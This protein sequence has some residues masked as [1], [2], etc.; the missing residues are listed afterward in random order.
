MSND[1]ENIKIDNNKKSSFQNVREKLNID[2]IKNK[3][4]HDTVAIT[5]ITLVSGLA[6]GIVHA[7]TAGPIAYQEQKAKEEAYK[8]VFSEAESFEPVFEE[9]NPDVEKH[10]DETGYTRQDIDEKVAAVDGAGNLVGYAYTVTTHEGYGGD[11]KFIVGVDKEGNVTPISILSISE[12]AGLGMRANTDEFKQQF[13]GKPATVVLVYTKDGAD[14]VFEI[15]ALS[16]AT[17]TTKAMTNGVNAG[18]ETYRYQDGNEEAGVA[19]TEEAAEDV[20]RAAPAAEEAPVVEEVQQPAETPAEAPVAEEVQQPAEAPVAEEVQQPAEAPV[21][22]EVQQPAEAPVVEEV[23]QPAE[24]PVVE[25]VQPAE[26][27]AEA[28]AEVP[29]AGEV[30][31]PAETP[32]EAPVAEETQQP[33][34]TPEEAPVAE[35]VQQPAET[36]A[37]EEVRQ[38][39][40]TPAAEEVQQPAETP[41]AEEV[42]QPAEEEPAETVKDPGLFNVFPVTKAAEAAAK[43]NKDMTKKEGERYESYGSKQ[44]ERA[45]A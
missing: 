2:R 27:P 39:A 19:V 45:S 10:L 35:E 36:P 30:Q 33:A 12:T 13:D 31:Q 29:A 11:I 32:A 6:L 20:T 43:E 15:D 28:P 18:L 41:A 24:A 21:V 25:E 9:Q 42:R 34:E 16:G 37:A 40:E 23:Q 17:V 4:L 7:I 26:A 8:D 1:K 44:S 38:P 3:L 14:E 22:E 5:V